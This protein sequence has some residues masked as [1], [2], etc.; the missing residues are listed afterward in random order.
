MQQNPQSLHWVWSRL[1]HAFI[2]MAYAY[3]QRSTDLLAGF[4]GLLL[5]TLLIPFLWIVN[6]LFARGPL[7]YR[8]TRVGLQGRHFMMIK[9]RSM[10]VTA[11]EQGVV[12]TAT[13][14]LR[15]TPVGW[16]LRRTHL[17]ELPQ[18]WNIVQGEMS[19]I[20]PR[21]E[22]PEFVA[23]LTQEIEGYAKRHR[24]KPGLTGWAQVNYGY[25]D[26]VEDARIKLRYDLDYIARQS[27]WL[28]LVIMLRTFCVLWKG[29]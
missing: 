17:D 26:S 23:Q 21:P 24:V 12:W 13:D 28:D 6:G 16:F 2:A 20:G 9:L 14:D 29:R 3:T 8:Q 11:E 22:R 18:C 19:L 4:L 15:I 25:G 7:F 1:P 5:L 27:A 10:V